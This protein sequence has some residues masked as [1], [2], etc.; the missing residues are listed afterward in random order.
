MPTI[1]LTDQ[2]LAF[3]NRFRMTPDQRNIAALTAVENNRQARL[4]AMTPENR[5]VAEQEHLDQLAEQARVATLT[6]EQREA[7]RLVKRQASLVTEAAQVEAD[8][9]K[10]EIDAVV[11]VLVDGKITPDVK[12]LPVVPVKEG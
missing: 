1:E 7:E 5:A 3:V 12:P 9:K 8:L 2:E 4:A 11:A 6:R 10:P